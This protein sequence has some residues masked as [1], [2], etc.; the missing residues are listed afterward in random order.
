MSNSFHLICLLLL[1]SV[2]S[3]I[4]TLEENQTGIKLYFHEILRGPNETSFIIAGPNLTSHVF[5]DIVIF[6]NALREGPDP[7]SK[8]IGQA[9]GTSVLA[10]QSDLSALTAIN[11]IFTDGSYNGSTI[12]L[13]GRVPA[14]GTAERTVIGGSGLFRM[15]MGYAIST[16]VNASTDAYI[17]EFN[18]HLLHY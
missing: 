17:V 13:F 5:G 14:S 4:G 18:F 10:S 7:N 9:Q 6:D 3:S 8:L 12:A 2:S 15:A 1:T 16:L 11:F